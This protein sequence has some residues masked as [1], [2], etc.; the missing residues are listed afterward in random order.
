MDALATN[1]S[2]DADF[3]LLTSSVGSDVEGL[4]QL[5]RA[6]VRSVGVHNLSG[7]SAAVDALSMPPA[8]VPIKHD[9][10]S[11]L[12]RVID[13]SAEELLVSE[14]STK[15]DSLQVWLKL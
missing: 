9:I 7:G 5:L 15:S 6:Q 10:D 8:S 2:A 14:H 13:V 11:R 12:G 4:M 3:T 1:T